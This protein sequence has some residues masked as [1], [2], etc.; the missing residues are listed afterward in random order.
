MQNKIKEKYIKI[1]NSNNNLLIFNKPWWL[2]L[3]T[4]NWD[5]IE[6]D[7][8]YENSILIPIFKKKKFFFEYS[9][10][11]S[12]VHKIS[13]IFLGKKE[14]IE[15]NFLDKFFLKIK[16]FLYYS[17][18]F[19][20]NLN[21]NDKNK[22]NNFIVKST[23]SYFVDKKDKEYHNKFD[24]DV[25]R[26]IKKSKNLKLSFKTINNVEFFINTFNENLN[27]LNKKNYFSN[28]Q[29]KEIYKKLIEKRSGK[30]FGVF[31]KNNELH[32]SA[33]VAWDKKD[34]YLIFLTSNNKLKKFGGSCYL[35]ERLIKFSQKMNKNFDFEGGADKSIGTFYKKFTNNIKQLTQIE[36]YKYIYLKKIINLFKY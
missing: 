27:E 36:F 17:I 30:I 4:I 12:L 8:D 18:T 28:I 15:F 31:D 2:D 22:K 32:S 11:P 24:A 7:Y 19:T 14:F 33:L 5:V 26:L 16:T 25:R 34:V 6:I 3:Q 23:K 29:I 20:E 35:I 9:V 1:T 21:L 10:L 13:P